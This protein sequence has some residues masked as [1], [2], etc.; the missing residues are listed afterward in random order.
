MKIRAHETFS[1]R[2]GWIS[3][4]I[5]NIKLRPRLFT[6]KTFNPCNILG[7]GTNMV[8]SLR[9]WLTATGVM[10]EKQ[11]GGQHI[12]R[13]TDLGHLIDGYDPYC[14]EEGTNWLLHYRLAS[15]QEG[16]TAW[17]WFFNEFNVNTFDREMFT[18]GLREYLAKE[19][20]YTCSEKTLD[21]EFSCFVRTYYTKQSEDPEEIITCPLA[22][23]G[24][25]SRISDTEYSRCVPDRRAVHPMIVYAV[26][27]DNY[28][29]DEILISDLE[30]GKNGPCRI[31]QF[32]K[33]TLFSV[34]EELQKTGYIGISRTAGLDV[35]TIKKRM[36]FI[37]AAEAYYRAISEE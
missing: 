1:I 4:G 23:L 28:F 5:K 10:E 8:K 3:K 31:F 15:N 35:I 12:Q 16:A 30:K 6:D 25:L 21:D 7:I 24:L 26:I 18:S 34:L 32:D 2:K 29:L 27:A 14:E 17:Y 13:L 19:Y 37:E 36:T 11:Q 22:G 9:Y 20:D 33:A